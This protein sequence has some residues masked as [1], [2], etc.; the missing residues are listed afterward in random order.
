MDITENKEQRVVESPHSVKA[1]ISL[2]LGIL[3]MLAWLLPFMGLPITIT[4]II[5]GVSGRKTTDRNMAFAG[6]VLSIIG[7]VLTIINAGIGAYL[8]ATG[9]LG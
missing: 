1:V 6:L 3:G 2:I 9:K 7:L 8:G 4:G 5:L